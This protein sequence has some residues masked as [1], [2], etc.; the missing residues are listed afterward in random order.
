MCK[1]NDNILDLIFPNKIGYIEIYKI[2]ENL[3]LTISYEPAEG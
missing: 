3:R 1:T 2:E